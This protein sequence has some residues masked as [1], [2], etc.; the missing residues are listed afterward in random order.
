MDKLNEQQI[1]KLIDLNYHLKPHHLLFIDYVLNDLNKDFGEFNTI[2][3]NHYNENK[4]KKESDKITDSDY[5]YVLE[6]L[7]SDFNCIEK[8]YKNEEYKLTTIGKAVAEKYENFTAFLEKE[9]N[10]QYNLVVEQQQKEVLEKEVLELQKDNLEYQKTIR[11]QEKRILD[12][13]E[14]TGFFGVLKGY[15]WL[16]GAIAI[17]FYAIGQF[18]HLLMNP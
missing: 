9:L 10:D 13:T 14:K 5:S 6:K 4:T 17:V 18:L 15:W 11:K 8:N 2:Y 16:L 1:N 12:L 7:Q 3:D